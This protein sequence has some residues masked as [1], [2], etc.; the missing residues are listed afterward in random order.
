MAHSMDELVGM[1]DRPILYLCMTYL[2][3]WVQELNEHGDITIVRLLTLSK[4]YIMILYL[5][6]N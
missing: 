5:L 2:A 4:H 3:Q 1:M 6:S